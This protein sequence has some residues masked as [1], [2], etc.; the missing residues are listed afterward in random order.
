MTP[1][2][3]C[4]RCDGNGRLDSFSHIEGGICFLCNGEGVVDFLP[5]REVIDQTADHIFTLASYEGGFRYAQVYVWEAG[6]G[7]EMAG[8]GHYYAV[9]GNRKE[10]C[11]LHIPLAQLRQHYKVLARSMTLIT[12]NKGFA[13]F[14]ATLDDK[15]RKAGYDVWTP[16]SPAKEAADMALEGVNP[17]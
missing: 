8:T 16:I 1:T 11:A 13:K 12:T 10:E 14:Q 6:T 3:V 9:D 4:P 7:K 2:H 5:E 15:N 17:E